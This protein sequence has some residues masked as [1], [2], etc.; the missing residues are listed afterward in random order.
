MVGCLLRPRSPR[1]NRKKKVQ[2]PRSDHHHIPSLTS[3]R[4][5]LSLGPITPRKDLPFSDQRRTLGAVSPALK[6]K[7]C[8][9]SVLLP[10]GAP[11]LRPKVK[12]KAIPRSGTT[13]STAI[14]HR[15]AGDQAAMRHLSVRKRSISFYRFATWPR[16]IRHRVLRHLHKKH[17]RWSRRDGFT[18][19]FWVP[20]VSLQRG[21]F[22]LLF[23]QPGM[24]D[25]IDIATQPHTLFS[26]RDRDFRTGRPP[27]VRASVPP[28]GSSDRTPL[29]SFEDK[30]MKSEQVAFMC[31]MAHYRR[32][33]WGRRANGGFC[34][35]LKVSKSLPN[36]LTQTDPPGWPSGS[37]AIGTAG[38]ERC[39]RNAAPGFRM[40][41]LR[42]CRRRE[43]NGFPPSFP[44]PG[45]SRSNTRNRHCEHVDLIYRV[46]V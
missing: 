31:F 18:I 9:R 46:S 7:G 8:G 29:M 5:V 24:G 41:V 13:T 45:H 39:H 44:F 17:P 12:A 32:V 33:G 11:S 19:G 23:V 38:S 6:W 2:S 30:I 35:C 21:L 37:G 36:G 1:R 15:M 16:T 28:P 40:R 4:P 34:F 10:T 26:R 43:L 22:T 27:S 42:C 25:C 14:L 20:R 3:F